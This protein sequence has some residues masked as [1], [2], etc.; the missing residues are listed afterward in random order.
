MY[1]ASV[2][3]SRASAVSRYSW[4][5]LACCV[6][7]LLPSSALA[8]KRIIFLGFSGVRGPEATRLIGR[9]LAGRYE[10]VGAG[11]YRQEAQ[12]RGANL[13]TASGRS[14]AARALR[15]V[16]IVSGSVVKTGLQWSLRV[17]VFSAH[18]GSSVGSLAYP[19]RGM[20]IDPLT[21]RRA[22]SGLTLALGR[23]RPGPAVSGGGAVA[24]APTR[25]RA[26]PRPARTPSVRV[27]RLPTPAR[28]RRP[29][30]DDG[31]ETN[32]AGDPGDVGG[33]DPKQ[34]RPVRPPRRAPR[35]A[36]NE[37]PVDEGGDESLGFDTGD[38]DGDGDSPPRRKRHRAKGDGATDATAQYTTKRKDTERPSWEKIFE[39]GAGVMLLSRNFD[40]N[41][42]RVPEHPSNYSSGMVPAILVDGSIY[43]F[44]IFGRNALANLG[45]VGSY[46]RVPVLRSK[47]ESGDP[48]DTTLHQFE[49]GLRYRWNILGRLTSPT[50]RAGLD[51]GRLGFVI[52]W[53]EG[54]KIS[55]P[56]IVYMYLKL[57][58]LGLQVP[59][60]ASKSFSIGASADFDYLYV[61]SAGDI[62]R[63]DS[64]G[65]GR[66][67]TGGINLGGGLFTT[68]GGFF[69]KV[70][71]FYRRMFFAFDNACYKANTGCNAAGGALDIYKG[72]TLIGGY[73]Y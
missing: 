31:S 26:S 13:G 58:I 64:G 49:V 16:A 27:E 53:A 29:D 9:S 22:A 1:T 2:Q 5:W 50:I 40:F 34:T 24:M 15:A 12:K 14:L 30:F 72:V 7:L 11:R 39:V 66:S 47:Q 17:S 60:Y 55:L 35:V 51:F 32:P 52:H 33:D 3:R 48:V 45:V 54:M 19:L 44:A 37:D 8:G 63:T 43:P 41:D 42:P 21:A 28:P 65:Y 18:N 70:T 25:P 46:Y 62:E 10:L 20:R 68:F 4:L 56:N 59:F 69:L 57:A 73:A 6:T 36:A 61:F 23:A 38:G 71:G 67:S